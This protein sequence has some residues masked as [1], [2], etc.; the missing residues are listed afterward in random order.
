MPKNVLCHFN[1]MV[2]AFMN[3]FLKKELQS[4]YVDIFFVF[5]YLY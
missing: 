3:F 2:I 4:Q 5:L 1:V